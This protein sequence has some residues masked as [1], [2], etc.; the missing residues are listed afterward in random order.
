MAG[1]DM[2]VYLGTEDQ[3]ADP[4]ISA[5]ES[6]DAPAFRGTAYV[7]FE[8]FPLAGFGNRLPQLNFEVVR[9]G[10]RSGRLEN[11]VQSVCLLPGSG[12]F[13]YAAEVVEERV[14][15]GETRP[16]NMN[17]LSGKADIELALDHVQISAARRQM[18]AYCRR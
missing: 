18:R 17:N 14:R 10:D 15:P 6:V 8:D 12:E 7:V 16:V 11:L 13:A 3:M 2:R 4:I 9:S 1:L 5:T